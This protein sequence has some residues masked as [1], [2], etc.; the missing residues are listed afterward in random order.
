MKQRL[1]IFLT[2]F[3]SAF[4]HAQNAD[5]NEIKKNY[6]QKIL[7]ENSDVL[8]TPQDSLELSVVKIEKEAEKKNELK[9]NP[10]LHQEKTS[11]ADLKSNLEIENLNLKKNSA[12]FIKINF[13][14]PEHQN[15][16]IYL[17]D[18][19]QTKEVNDLKKFL[20]LQFKPEKITYTSKEEA[21]KE[22]KN[23]LGVEYS[24]LFEENIFPAS[25]EITTKNKINIE[26]LKKK[27][28]YTIDDIKSNELKIK[29][30]TLKIKT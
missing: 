11:L 7:F 30:I 13:P 2:L 20:E 24:E 9:N 5:W 27:Y 4:L 17:K 3:L 25:L 14:K 23:L 8:L 29:S 12:Y 19:I 6:F 10:P 15:Y 1:K 22:A 21:S 28:P 26:S 18:S 16:T